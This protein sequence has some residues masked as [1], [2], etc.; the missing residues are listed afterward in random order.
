MVGREAGGC[1][2]IRAWD[3]GVAITTTEEVCH[4][5]AAAYRGFK[6]YN[7]ARHWPLAH[8]TLIRLSEPIA[9]GSKIGPISGTELIYAATKD[10]SGL[11]LVVRCPQCRGWAMGFLKGTRLAH[12]LSMMDALAAAGIE[13]SD[14]GRM[15]QWLESRQNVA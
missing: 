11:I 8:P 9:T 10:S 7:R 1:R 5:S 2:V 15:V 4:A 13:W 6:R 3:S 12:R 14:A